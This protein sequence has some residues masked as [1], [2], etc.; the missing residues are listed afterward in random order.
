MF[1]P[2]FN[3]I[4]VEKF[5]IHESRILRK[6]RGRLLLPRFFPRH[7]IA[8][9]VAGNSRMTAYLYFCATYFGDLLINEVAHG[10]LLPY[11]ILMNIEV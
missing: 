5:R 10:V 8:V 7:G 11:C 2:L 6:P 1:L 3:I 9:G 4:E